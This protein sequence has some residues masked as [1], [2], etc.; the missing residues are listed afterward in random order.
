MKAG[1]L[2]LTKIW[3][4][5][6]GLQPVLECVSI[7]L[8]A[9]VLRLGLLAVTRS[10]LGPEGS[11]VVNVA[12]SLAAH[13]TFAN[14]F[15]PT[16]G[17]TAHVS[18][19]YPLLLS[20]LYRWFGTGQAGELAQEVFASCIAALLWALLPLA[21]RILGRGQGVGMVAGLMGALLP[22]NRWAEN[23]GSFE[24]PLAALMLLL[25]VSAYLY[26]WNDGRFS[27]KRATGLGILGGL[28]ILVSATLG[29][30]Q[31][32]LLSFCFLARR[33]R[34]KQTLAFAAVLVTTVAAVLLPWGIRNYYA[35]GK[36]VVTRSNFGLELQVSN[37]DLATA[38]SLTNGPSFKK[39]HPHEK[40][41]QLM[42]LENVGE[43]AYNRQKLH[44][45]IEWIRSHP[46]RFAELSLSRFR[47]FWFPDLKR[48]VQT[49]VFRLL[50]LL[51]LLGGVR[52]YRQ[53][54]FLTLALISV[55]GAYSLIYYL[56][57]ADARYSYPIAWA[58]YLFAADFVLR[59]AEYV[60]AI[61]QRVPSGAE[62]Q[63]PRTWAFLFGKV[64]SARQ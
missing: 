4:R 9:L 21:G 12:R 23:K 34:R 55:I 40:G 42:R 8:I 20:V 58:I 25:L 5:R 44:Q 63:A 47:Y 35:L 31:V 11:E 15:S 51:A 59:A 46:S 29:A 1:R 50:A 57:Q 49:V 48:P 32:V 54:R 19:A 16:S 24:T 17:A 2:A 56:V 7:F 37:N 13:G 3:K 60:A 30:V 10:Y 26:T 52:L 33:D 53:D 43:I 28:A 36:F 22:V 27:L 39:Y 14:A 38:R 62:V 18:P 61:T 45:A 64:A 6:S 41:K